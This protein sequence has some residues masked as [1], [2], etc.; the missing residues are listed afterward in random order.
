MVVS[1]SRRKTNGVWAAT[2][3]RPRKTAAS[4]AAAVC[5]E[6]KLGELKKSAEIRLEGKLSDYLNT[7]SPLVLVILPGF[8]VLLSHDQII[9]IIGWV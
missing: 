4:T 7:V 8:Y 1:K 3:R 2:K 9:E 6:A 5:L